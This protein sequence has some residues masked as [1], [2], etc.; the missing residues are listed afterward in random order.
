MFDVAILSPELIDDLINLRKVVGT[1][2]STS[3]AMESIARLRQ[4]SLKPDISSVETFKRAMLNAESIAYFTEGRAASIFLP[5]STDSE[6][7]EHET[8]AEGL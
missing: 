7:R 6:S 5:H 2:A 4:N 3:V 1:R 8:K